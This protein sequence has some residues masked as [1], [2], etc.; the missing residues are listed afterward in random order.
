MNLPIS[1]VVAEAIPTS[2]ALKQVANYAATSASHFFGDLLQTDSTPPK[3]SASGSGRSVQSDQNPSLNPSSQKKSWSDRA[4]SL[5]SYLSKFLMQSRGR[6]GLP[7]NAE[8]DQGI[9]ISADGSGAPT[10]TGPEPFRTELQNHL[11]ENPSV[12][13]ELNDLAMERSTN[14]PLRLLPEHDSR[15]PPGEKWKLWL[16]T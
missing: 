3:P 4:E 10:L 7:P 1:W 15:K 9:S 11:R 16:D 14:E 8:M 2:Q 12:V 5:R 6:Y 13:K